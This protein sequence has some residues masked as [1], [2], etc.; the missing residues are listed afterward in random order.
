MVRVPV[1]G[2][3][4]EPGNGLIEYGVRRLG[5]RFQRCDWAGVKTRCST[6][7]LQSHLK[8]HLKTSCFGIIDEAKANEKPAISAGSLE[9]LW[10]SWHVGIEF[11]R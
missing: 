1:S 8:L 5:K 9:Y 4:S 10:I 7:V 6:L 2:G 11:K 3:L